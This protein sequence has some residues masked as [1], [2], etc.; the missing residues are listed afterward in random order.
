MSLILKLIISLVIAIV[1]STVTTLLQDGSIPDMLL[2]A[3]FSIATVATALLVSP[4][5]T[6]STAGNSSAPANSGS[7]NPAPRTASDDSARDQG[8]V[9]WFNVSKGF[10]FI[11]KD[12]GEEIFV[13]F[14]S[15]RGEGRRSLR[16]GQRVSFV[17][18][19]S[20]KGPQA[21]DVEGLD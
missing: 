3:A 4:S 17:V 7:K 9:K 2:L 18:A 13:H 5:A 11:T 21:E 16:D 10:G 20:D 1:A 19:Q 8:Q 6:P 12:D 15:I 14:R